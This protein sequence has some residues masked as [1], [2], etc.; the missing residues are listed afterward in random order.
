MAIK[1]DYGRGCGLAV[2]LG[3]L[4]ERW[5]MLVVRELLI[6]PAR[7]TALL[8][9]MPGIGPNLLS[10]RLRTL[11]EHGVVEQVAIPGD[12]RAQRYRLTELGEQLRQPLLAL[13]RWGLGFL[14]EDDSGGTTRAEW[15]FLAVQSM[16]VREAVPE[17]DDTY[18]FEVGGQDFV[19]EVRDGDV[20]FA[21][22]ASPEPDM[23]VSC[24]AD[25]F[26]RV[27][28]RLTSPAEMIATGAVRVSGDL[29]AAGRCIRMLGL[30]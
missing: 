2:G 21:R 8:E 25:T 16:V 4:G 22:G 27:G 28:A 29:A 24:D 15:G 26:I 17:V 10:E 5:T 30:D 1:Q 23:T 18:Q 20:R 6:G 9:N 13:A 7:F 3:V 11:A 14:R 19:I 12:G